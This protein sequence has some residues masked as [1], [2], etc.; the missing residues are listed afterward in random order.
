MALQDVQ[1]P[2][3]GVWHWRHCPGVG[4]EGVYELLD[5]NGDCRGTWWPADD[6]KP[7]GMYQLL[8]D[9]A[10]TL[11]EREPTTCPLCR[12]ES[13]DGRPC[14]SCYEDHR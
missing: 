2:R 10:R 11:Q 4:A 7:D 14:T 3:V 8:V 12:G 13:T 5:P 6:G 1:V 9:L